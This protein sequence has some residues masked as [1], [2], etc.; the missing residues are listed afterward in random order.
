[1]L[2][3][4]YHHPPRHTKRCSFLSRIFPPV[5]MGCSPEGDPLGYGLDPGSRILSLPFHRAME[6][7]P[8]DPPDIDRSA[9]TTVP[10]HPASEGGSD[11]AGPPGRSAWET[12]GTSN[13]RSRTDVLTRTCRFERSNGRATERSDDGP[14]TAPTDVVHNR[15]NLRGCGGHIRPMRGCSVR[16]PIDVGQADERCDASKTKRETNVR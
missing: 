6:W 12:G 2:P 10:L 7:G 9:D 15:M 11:V 4:C 8:S 1:M 16:T 3:P 13:Q 14:E 5:C